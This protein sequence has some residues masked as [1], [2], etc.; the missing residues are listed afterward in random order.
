MNMR[1][2]MTL[3]M[4]MKTIT[5]VLTMPMLPI[6]PPLP[7]S[8]LKTAELLRIKGLTDGLPDS[9]GGKPP[10]EDPG[11]RG[12]EQEARRQEQEARRQEQEARR[13][14]PKKEEQVVVP[15]LLRPTTK[16]PSSVT[17]EILNGVNLLPPEKKLKIVE[18]SDKD[19]AQLTESE[20]G[21]DYDGEILDYEDDEDD[22]DYSGEHIVVAGDAITQQASIEDY[23]DE[24]RLKIVDDNEVIQFSLTIPYNRNDSPP[25]PLWATLWS[26]PMPT[27]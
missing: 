13:C 18:E 3:M 12:Q 2:V 25:S 26:H 16:R 4:I 24:N 17:D 27:S 14:S 5:P 1:M 8:F 11:A 20:H 7:Q 9:G 10:A 6:M 19:E 15:S 22:E 23:D 21:D